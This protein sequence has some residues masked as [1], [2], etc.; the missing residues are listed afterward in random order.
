MRRTAASFQPRVAVNCWL[1]QVRAKR[2]ICWTKLR[3]ALRKEWAG[4]PGGGAAYVESTP[5]EYRRDRRD[6]GHRVPAFDEPQGDPTP[7]GWCRLRAAGG[8]RLARAVDKLGSRR[9]PIALDWRS[10]SPWLCHEGH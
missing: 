10:Q 9:N 7:C 8:D 1:P 5:D 4:K 6:P 2:W 3:H